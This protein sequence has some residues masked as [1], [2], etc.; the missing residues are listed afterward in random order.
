MWIRLCLWAH[1]CISSVSLSR[2]QRWLK[3]GFWLSFFKKRL[4]EL[5]TQWQVSSLIL[6]LF[7]HQGNCSLR[8]TVSFMLGPGFRLMFALYQDKGLERWARILRESSKLGRGLRKHDL[9]GDVVDSVMF[10]SRLNCKSCD[11]LFSMSMGARQGWLD[12]Q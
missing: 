7:P 3:G 4:Y 2:V 9:W 10:F 5:M 12:L 6:F 11:A 8:A 1:V